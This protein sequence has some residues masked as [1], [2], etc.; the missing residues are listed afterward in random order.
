MIKRILM[1]HARYREEGGEDVSVA[2]A[3]DA[4]QKAGVGVTLL[5]LPAWGEASWFPYAA[6]KRI[7]DALNRNVYD[8]VHIHNFFPSASVALHRSALRRAIPIVQHIR[9]ARALC[10]AARLWREGRVCGDCASSPWPGIARGCWRGSRL[11]TLGA[12]YSVR[13]QM[14]VWRRVACFVF[15]S[16]FLRTAV[17][18]VLGGMPSAIVPNH[19]SCLLQTPSL[20]GQRAG[21]VYAG[22]LVPEKGVRTLLKA[23]EWLDPDVP[24]SVYGVGP[25]EDEVRQ[26]ERRIR[27]FGQVP[28]DDIMY[29]MEKALVVVVPSVWPEPFGRTAL[30]GL[31]AGAAVVAS[32]VGGV[33]EVVDSC[34]FLVPPGD[35]KALAMAMTQALFVPD[36]V[37]HRARARAQIL[38][39]QATHGLIDVY[40]RCLEKASRHAS[41]AK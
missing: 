12:T 27:F 17:A 28:S 37:R 16:I 20:K 15:P 9:N 10:P 18:P 24:V 36:D 33:P 23:L 4:L 14:D 34:G 13:W 1:V 26:H 19:A 7:E 39:Q 31:A 21:V 2:L 32:S 3:C 29:A 30:E 8:L 11:L 5:C 40:S 41:I 38:H 6:E 22:R 35:P 25:L